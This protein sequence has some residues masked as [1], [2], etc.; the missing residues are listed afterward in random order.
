MIR[1]QVR[2]FVCEQGGCGRRTFAEQITG[3]TAPHARFSP[4]AQAALTTV[5]AVMAGRPGAR[6]ATALGMPVGRDTLLRLLRAQP[7]P[8]VGPITVVGVDDFALRRGNRYA[9]ILVDLLTRRPIEVLPGRDAAPVADWLAHHPEVQVVCRDR[10]RAYAEAARTGAPQAQQ[11]AD[12]WHLWHNLCQAVEKTVAAHHGCIKT[13]Y[14]TAQPAPPEPVAPEPLDGHLDVRGRPRRLVAR[15]TDRYTDIQ[16]RVA[17]GR[18]LRGISR[19]LGLDYYAVRRYARATSLDELLATVIHR[20]SVLDK[21]KPYLYEQ[22]V[23]GQT[24][25]SHLFRQIR[26]RGYPGSRSTVSSYL[27][28]LKAGVIAP[29]PPRPV[30]RPRAATTWMLTHPDHL[31]PDHTADLAEVQAACPELVATAGHVRSFA[32]M[33]QHR[34]GQRLTAWIDQV[35]AD[36]LPHLRQFA[37]GLLTDRAAVV[38]GLSTEYNSGQ[39]EGQNT[40]T[41]LIKRMGYGRANF[42][43]LRKRILLHP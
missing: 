9:T 19:D 39:V 22:F 34:R 17:A 2:R 1:V 18:S 12:R 40:R 24:N 41:K 16:Q 25:A 14:A 3:L 20:R 11:V 26:Q 42:D 31:Q 36:D 21:F 10:A 13:A 30:P 4:P 5:T 29:P 27:Q 15:I 7:D 37:E 32:A 28:Q 23:A 38:A 43:L 33:M 35:R 6:L 8:P